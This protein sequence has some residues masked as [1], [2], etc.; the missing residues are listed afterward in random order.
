MSKEMFAALSRV[1][2]QS[3][4]DIEMSEDQFQVLRQKIA[5]GD[6]AGFEK[7]MV[8]MDTDALMKNTPKREGILAERWLPEKS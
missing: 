3:E 8:R 2:C 4:D 7:M 1:L 6:A 5:Q